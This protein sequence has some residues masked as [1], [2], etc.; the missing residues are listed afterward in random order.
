MSLFIN[1][2]LRMFVLLAPFFAVSM[3]LKMSEGMERAD[4]RRAAC[5]CGLTVL[6]AI[7][8]CYFFG[9]PLFSIM[10][11]TLASFQIG[12]GSTLFISSILM[13][14]GTGRRE[15]Q[16]TKTTNHEDDFAVVP[17]ALPIIVGPG[18]IGTLMVWG[19]QQTIWI[20]RSTTCLAML[21]A[22]ITIFIFLLL[23]ERI[24][25]LIG[26]K[27][28]AIMTKVTALILTAIAAQIIFTG[29][30]SMLSDG[31]VV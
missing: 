5:R 18:T 4:R 29:V 21:L 23:A 3:F 15:I 13:I 2:Y 24:E 20:N 26:Q 1:A 17:L 22:A 14:L 10:G 30:R 7:F 6:I 19:T 11:I 28:L 16:P 25:R 9:R 8:V 27:L 12:A 31:P